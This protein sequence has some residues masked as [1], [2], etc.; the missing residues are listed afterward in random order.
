MGAKNDYHTQYVSNAGCRCGSLFSWRIFEGEDPPLSQVLHPRA[1][2]RRDDLLHREL[3]PLHRG[4]MELQPGHRH[5]ELVHDALLL[6]RTIRP[7]FV[8]IR[9]R[10]PWVCFLQWLFGWNVIF[11]MYKHLLTSC[12]AIYLHHNRI[13]ISKRRGDVNK[14]WKE[15]YEPYMIL[16]HCAIN[17]FVPHLI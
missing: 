7:A 2:H 17:D 11:A 12:C 6:F 14:I 9:A 4:D 8:F 10:K 1:G 5:A 15:I 3:Y 13:I 16:S